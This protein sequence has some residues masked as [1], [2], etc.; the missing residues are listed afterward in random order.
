[1]AE[2]RSS[3]RAARK[4]EVRHVAEQRAGQR[5]ARPI[6]LHQSGLPPDTSPV[7]RDASTGAS[8]EPSRHDTL[9]GAILGADEIAQPERRVKEGWKAYEQRRSGG[10][11]RAL[12]ALARGL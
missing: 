6:F 5:N 10:L 1:V 12:R 7:K 3:P 2:D 4:T 8:V 11:P 9:R